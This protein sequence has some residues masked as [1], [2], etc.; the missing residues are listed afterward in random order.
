MRTSM[1]RTVLAASAAVALLCPPGESAAQAPGYP[2]KAIR[3]VNPFTP[4]GS[5]DIVARA[6]SQRFNE[7]WHQ[8]V[9]VDNR[10]GAGTTIGTALVVRA[11]P[12]G[13]TLLTTTG[14]IAVNASLYQNLAFDVAKDLT[15]IAQVVQTPSI[16]AVNLALPAKSVAE[17]ISLAKGKPGQLNFASSGAGTSTHLTMEIFR[18]MAKIDMLHVPYKGATPAIA[19]VLGGEVQAI[20][21]PITAVLPQARAGKM[22]ALAISSAKR[23]ELAPEL[24]TVAESGLPGFEVMIWYAV[25]APAGTPRRIVNQL[26]GEINRMLQ[27][28]E[29][30][31]SF[32]KIGMLPV[33]GT[34]EALGAHLKAEIARYA[35]IVKETGLKPVE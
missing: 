25:F 24:P 34:P 32:L 22:R 17:F 9:I 4:G 19:A 23:V 33:G 8:P 28:P 30:R 26:N 5:V 1:C 10:P 7:A 14:T 13:Y 6:V 3:M 12:D 20:F 15:P 31:Q 35:K 16:L 2:T 11:M 29:S 21:N 27:T 18:S